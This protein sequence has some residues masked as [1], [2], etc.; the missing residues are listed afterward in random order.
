MVNE[1]VDPK[2]HAFGTYEESK[3]RVDLRIKIPQALSQG[4]KR[5]S[6]LKTAEGSLMLTQGRVEDEEDELEDEEEESGKEEEPVRK[7]GKVFITKPQKPT[8]AVFTR[9]TRK[10]KSEPVSIHPTPT[11]EE[12]MK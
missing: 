8:T 2:I 9:R 6:K 5:V 11:F 10:G 7:K 3:K 4:K 1:P 12:R